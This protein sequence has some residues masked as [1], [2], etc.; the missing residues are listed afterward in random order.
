MK[1]LGHSLSSFE[2][3]NLLKQLD[4]DGS[5]RVEFAEFITHIATG[6]QE[7]ESQEQY[8]DWDDDQ[9]QQKALKLQT[10]DV[11]KVKEATMSYTIFSGRNKDYYMSCETKHKN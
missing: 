5:G 4:S 3:E 6:H 11:F 7:R 2:L 1:E 8:F 9:N 10:S